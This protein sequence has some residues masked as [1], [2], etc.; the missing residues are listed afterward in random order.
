MSEFTLIDDMRELTFV[1]LD[2]VSGGAA[3]VSARV[4]GDAFVSG[5]FALDNLP[6]VFSTASISG[7]MTAFSGSP[8]LTLNASADTFS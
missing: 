5:N 4:V 3:S 2:E 1:E 6:G 8:T 7:T